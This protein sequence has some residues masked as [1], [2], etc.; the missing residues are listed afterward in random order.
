MP[1]RC[2]IDFERKI[3]G[4]LHQVYLD[5]SVKPMDVLTEKPTLKLSKSN[6]DKNNFEQLRPWHHKSLNKGFASSITNGPLLGYP[7]LGA[8]FELHAVTPKKNTSENIVA[9][10]MIEAVKTVLKEA[11]IAL[12]EPMMK[13]VINAEAS[14]VSNLINDLFMRRGQVLERKDI[15]AGNIVITAEA[16]LSELRGY[17][18]QLR[19]ISSGKA[20][21]GMEFCHYE[22]M[23]QTDQNKAIKE[24]TG[25]D[26]KT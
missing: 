3:S 2:Q 8:S 5:I 4:D 26:P 14:V 10:A 22:L 6:V 25:F 13:L 24:I 7:V 1:A 17:S 20:I 18:T 21:F 12:M 9:A 23:D 15:S 16:P 19:I 11:N